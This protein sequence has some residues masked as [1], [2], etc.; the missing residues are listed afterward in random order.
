VPVLRGLPH[1][2]Y[3]NYTLLIT[4]MQVVFFAVWF[5]YGN[6]VFMKSLSPT[7][8]CDAVYED[9]AITGQQHFNPKVLQVLMGLLMLFHWFV[10]IAIVQLLIFTLML[11][12]LWDGVVHATKR[13]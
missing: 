2:L 1:G 13:M 12:S 6:A 7:M 5:F 10:F 8:E 9:E 11:W 3:F 4:L